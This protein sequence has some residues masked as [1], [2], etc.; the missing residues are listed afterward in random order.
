M[1]LEIV[2]ITCARDSVPGRDLPVLIIG[3]V[4]TDDQRRGDSP[5]VAAED[6]SVFKNELVGIGPGAAE[7]EPHFSSRCVP[8][9]HAQS[10][11]ISHDRRD[12]GAIGAEAS[13]S[14]W[15]G[16]REE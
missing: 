8:Y 16:S 1:P 12:P 5:A 9:P 13:E 3:P 14:R 15:A 11:A 10:L 6:R 4:E 2:R 7:V